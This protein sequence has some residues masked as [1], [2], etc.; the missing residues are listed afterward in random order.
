MTA[1]RIQPFVPFTGT[2]SFIL[3]VLCIHFRQHLQINNV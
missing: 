2:V 3:A 1:F